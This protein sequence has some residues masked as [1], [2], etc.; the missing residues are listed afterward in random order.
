MHYDTAEEAAE[1]WYRRAKRI[2]WGCIIYKISERETFTPEIMQMFVN[3]PFKNKL[4]FASKKYTEDTVLIENID[5]FVGDENP[6]I[7]KHF[8]ELEYLNELQR[9]A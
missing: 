1:K 5:T 7:E 2:N 3:L 6:L 9:K 4:I 8:D